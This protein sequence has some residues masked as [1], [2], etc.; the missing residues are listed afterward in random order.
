[1]RKAIVVMVMVATLVMTLAAAATAAPSRPG[2]GCIHLVPC[3]I[4]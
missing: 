2:K 3:S 4:A 1:M